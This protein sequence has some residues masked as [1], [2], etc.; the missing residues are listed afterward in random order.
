MVQ[1][2]EILAVAKSARGS[3]GHSLIVSAEVV[4]LIGI[5]RGSVSS[6]LMAI[7]WTTARS[8]QFER[9]LATRAA[10]PKLSSAP[11]SPSR[12][13]DSWVTALSP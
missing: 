11:P 4:W 12:V 3:H 13:A 10:G 7:A 8:D 5:S 6:W 1:N 2:S 9:V